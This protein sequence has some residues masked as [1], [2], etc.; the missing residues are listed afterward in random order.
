MGG[1]FSDKE[2]GEFQENRK[3]TEIDR[4]QKNCEV[5]MSFVLVRINYKCC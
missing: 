1:K 4:A 2:I 3:N 5:E